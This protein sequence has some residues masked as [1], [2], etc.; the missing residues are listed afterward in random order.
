[1]RWRIQ[2][3]LQKSKIQAII[4]PSNDPN[5]SA[6]IEENINT[7][8]SS[9]N[10]EGERVLRVR[11]TKSVNKL[12]NSPPESDNDSS[13][14]YVSENDGKS[15]DSDNDVFFDSDDDDADE[16]NE[17]GEPDRKSKRR[18][19]L[20]AMWWKTGSLAALKEREERMSLVSALADCR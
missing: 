2:Q 17:E 18:K 19:K 11:P 6:F 13:P 9:G 12:N 3:K 15:S 8:S 1:L 16:V 7:S 20:K 5:T 10:V 4:G 14:D